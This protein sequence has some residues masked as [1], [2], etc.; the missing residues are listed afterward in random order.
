MN[1]VT[2]LPFFMGGVAAFRVWQA[3]RFAR[4]PSQGW[5]LLVASGLLALMLASSDHILSLLSRFGLERSV[6]AIVFGMLVLS[7]CY[8]RNPILES[9]PLRNLGK[10]SFSLYLLHPMIMI[11]LIKLDFPKYVVQLT[12]TTMVNFLI[13]SVI[14]IG[15]VW[16]FSTLSFRFV[17]A[18][19]IELGKRF[20]QRFY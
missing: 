10:L 20:A 2:H 9:G 6:W 15:L 19:G 3:M 16:M 12:D 7:A 13:A 4:L 8:A 17:E 14:S 11:I 5:G 18:P 1:L